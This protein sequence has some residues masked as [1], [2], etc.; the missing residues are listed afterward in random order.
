M[1]AAAIINEALDSGVL[2]YLDEGKLKF[3]SKKGAFADNLKQQIR[4]NKAAIISYL[5][6]LEADGNRAA[7]KI[8]PIEK[9][10]E[11]S[12]VPLSYSQ[13]R[14][15]LIDQIDGASAH[16]N[17]S[18]AIVLKG[19]INFSAMEESFNS[20]I[21]RHEVL[22]TR[23]CSNENGAYQLVEAASSLIIPCHDLTIYASEIQ[24]SELKKRLL[25][26]AAKPFDLQNDLM[27]RVE[28]FRIA[29]DECVVH[30]NM[31]HIA[32][33]SWSM[34]ILVQEFSRLYNA[35]SQDQK[36]PLLPLDIQYSDY[37]QWQRDW[38]QGDVLEAR[39]QYWQEKLQ[40]IP[41]RHNLPLD[42]PRPAQQ[43]FR[44]HSV[45]SKLETETSQQL[46][47]LCKKSGASLFMGL[48]AAFSVLL[49]R[50]SN[51][52]DI[53]IG[54]PI[55]N[56]EQIE[57]CN[58]IG[59]FVN[60]LVLRSNLSQN[61]SFEELIAQ[62]KQTLLDGYAHQQVSFD[63]L[64]ERL[65]P[66]RSSSYS[67]LFQVMLVLQNVNGGELDLNGISLKLIEAQPNHAK[68][69]LLLNV[70]DSEQGLNLEWEYATDLF[71]K[72]TIER[73]TE[74]FN[75]LLK[76]LVA[77][78][79]R[80]VFSSELVSDWE[81]AQI[82]RE[83]NLVTPN[84]AEGKSI[85][86]LFEQAV[87]QSPNAVAVTC[88]ER[89]ITYFELNAHANQLAHYLRDQVQ[90]NPD[91][92]VGLSLDRSVDLVI[93]IVAILKSGCAY[94]PLDPTYPESRLAY[95]LADAKP[96]IVITSEDLA[97]RL[98]LGE[99]SVICIDCA[100]TYENISAQPRDNISTAEIGL[101]ARHLAYVIY[102][103]GS[104]GMPKG[105]QVEHRNLV[106]STL[107]RLEFYQTPLSAFLLLSP[108]GFDSS[109]AGIFWSLISS[110]KLVIAQQEQIQSLP[111]LV[112]LIQQQRINYLL[113]IPSLYKEL[114]LLLQKQ[115]DVALDGVILAGE[116]LPTAVVHAHEQLFGA[117]CDLFNE[118]GPTEATVWSTA[119]KVERGFNG[120]RVPI[121]R[122]PNL[123]TLYVFNE[124]L[125]LCP[126]GTLGELY[127]G[128]A[129]IARGYLNRN[130]LT[131]SRFV[132]NPLAEHS[133]ANDN[134]L[135][136]T[137][138]LVRWL[139]DGSLEFFGRVDN[140][141][142][143][144][145]YR[146]ELGEIENRLAQC[147]GVESVAVQRHD[148]ATGE[149]LV[150]YV[151]AQAYS[152]Q[153]HK[154]AISQIEDWAR[155]HLPDFM[156]PSQYVMVD[157][158]PLSPNGKLDRKALMTLSMETVSE[159]YQPP[160]TTTEKYLC[161][162]WQDLLKRDTIGVRDNFFRLGGHSLL[163]SRMIGRVNED[164]RV[165]VP[166]KTLFDRQTVEDFA[167]YIDSSTPAVAL[168]SLTKREIK[169]PGL[170]LPLSYAQQQLWLL[171]QI[172][173]GSAHY[174]MPGVFHLQG[175]LDL[176][177][178]RSALNT[179]VARHESL[180]TKIRPD[181]HGNPQQIIQSSAS[182]TVPLEDLM[183]LQG[184]TLQGQLAK[185]ISSELNYTFDLTADLM[186]RAKIFRI[187]EAE[188]I[189]VFNMHHISSDGW[190][191][192]VL[193]RE[194][195]EL[196][197]S[198]IEGDSAQLPELNIQYA[199]YAIWQRQWLDGEI[200]EQQIDYWQK[201][202]LGAP[203]LHSLPLDFPRPRQQTF[204]GDLCES[205][206]SEALTKQLKRFCADNESTLYMGLHAA[207]SALLSRCSNET[208]I[209]IGSPIA[210]REHAQL[211]DLIG[212][213]VN[214]L[215]LRSDLSGS[216]SF[217]DLV[218]AS[219]ETLLG[220]YSHQ[221]VPFEKIVERMQPQRSLS[222]S[223]L[224][225]IMLVL[226]N[227]EQE[228]LTL[229][230]LTIK[231]VSSK[232]TVAK[233]DL[234]LNVLEQDNKLWLRWEFNRDLFKAET[235]SQMSRYFEQLLEKMLTTPEKNVFSLDI[236]SP[237]QSQNIL[238]HYNATDV[239][240]PRQQT[241][242]K[243]FEQQ[244]ESNSD[245]IALECDDRTWT[246]AKLNNEA[247]RLAQYL[248][249]EYQIQPDTL[250]GVCLE[251]SV[252]M[253]VAVLAILK[254]G[255]AY[256][257]L[258]P[259]QPQRRLDDMLAD[260]ALSLVVCHE[261]SVEKF[262][263]IKATCVCVDNQD[264]HAHLQQQSTHNPQLESQSAEN[265]AYLIF[266]SGSTGKPKASELIHRGLV[267][268]SLGQIKEFFVETNS[269]ILQFA[270]FSFDAATSEIFMALLSG[271]TLILPTG[272]ITKSAEK[273]SD[274]VEA[275]GITHVTL[276]PVL[277]PLLNREQW[278]SVE[279][280]IVAGDA[281]S[282]KLADI[283]CEGRRFINAYGPSEATVCATIGHYQPEQQKLHIGKPMQNVQVYVLNDC[284]Q[285]APPG[286]V[287]ELY[288]GGLG[289][290]RGYRN[291]AQLNVE[292]FVENP[293]YEPGRFASSEKLYRT[294]DLVRWNDD[295]NLEFIGRVDHQVKIRGMR[296]ELGEIES[297]L[298]SHPMVDDVVVSAMN[299]DDGDRKIVAHLASKQ[300]DSEDQSAQRTYSAAMREYLL[301]KLPDYMVP[302]GFV[303]L[304]RLPVTSNGKVDRTALPTPDFSL[305]RAVYIAPKTETENYL[306][307]LCEELLKVERIGMTDNFFV[308]GGHSLLAT[309]LVAHINQQFQLGLT[310]Q[311]VFNCQ[312]LDALA[313]CIEVEQTL[314]SIQRGE[315]TPLAS[316][317]MELVL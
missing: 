123:G 229:P 70:V 165:S 14:L 121:G 247:N 228:E 10:Q 159:P 209:I 23:F 139:A 264:L 306:C 141:V 246:Y 94:V 265:L 154:Q 307:A 193:I 204:D 106:A 49:A 116:A 259:G 317:E 253:I 16:Y 280:L 208:D 144:R 68:Y 174:N 251:R 51:E 102:T 235:I 3:K 185:E 97:R 103:S 143:I 305:Q 308:L 75:Q 187:T 132:T 5:T 72:H 215:V 300:P 100:T 273:L 30:I 312:T 186:L 267:N 44:G 98:P 230:D 245:K 148:T 6:D 47:A 26:S 2:L 309:K 134:R 202:L 109:V 227:N 270:S 292:K 213:F 240:I 169:E 71:H 254:A 161:V 239:E 55:A 58:L 233:Y 147:D 236:L 110:A 122:S 279:T 286:C 17:M 7:Q 155:Q 59:F 81:L 293:F 125:T 160:T 287:G 163:A 34:G 69:D 93:G 57:I 274:F 4:E 119:H 31:H 90:L 22:R 124:Q 43:S 225:Q 41:E 301:S 291:R 252:D 295:G 67:P 216:P 171:D 198:T 79:E 197:R 234:T 108:C 218:V 210:N 221:Q 212:F 112:N 315:D 146:I 205:E 152:P 262:N 244:V 222:H 153:G 214:N 88:G 13:Q 275:K 288:V 283:W 173:G 261:E 28:L 183:H 136:R 297:A 25:E 268:L 194:F 316:D 42:F 162:L 80:S 95:M 18:G 224:F 284:M 48:H 19:A 64:V 21:A 180:R 242:Q 238:N 45:C 256:V 299:A 207:F 74:R 29:D 206:I 138:D 52:T 129:G 27:L 37:A 158:F 310:L 289:L 46:K 271:S 1:S 181:Q 127:V 35:Y 120:M 104:T 278:K 62:S 83:W 128:G 61:P 145:G 184:A 258:D 201:K 172:G 101:E 179:V 77:A 32:S 84:L 276:P 176:D 8:P 86:E 313:E 285:A 219:R 189:L 85:H 290:S 304:S 294:G 53:V 282:T 150:A 66:Q 111:T 15:W 40:G 269:R 54:S 191:I 175:D 20:I 249:N 241:V 142:K 63:Q 130:D 190:S 188:Y 117:D 114:L 232:G 199:D 91:T 105:V 73:M 87:R 314:L 248:L 196:Y 39:L 115:A 9:R 36:N 78:P 303:W 237:Y 92:L 223:P 38:L 263:H 65:Q 96:K 211:A 168:P 220:A 302:V 131:L 167:K 298:Q 255:G 50:Y 257:P 192:A 60:N 296:I 156:Q 311:N 182:I 151:I 260:T 140:Q 33:D 203:G 56:R 217:V 99:Q 164:F 195:C 272:D 277:L 149:T 107:S 137:G 89:S 126:P 135:Y 231:P 281:C 243:L 11:Q 82:T 266:T 24:Q 133:C 177:A 200:L 157:S 250:V 178:V 113:A 170:D 166:V 76:A 118:Y 226:Q 12:P